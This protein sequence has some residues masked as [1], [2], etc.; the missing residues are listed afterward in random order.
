MLFI[1]QYNEGEG[2]FTPTINIMKVRLTLITE[3]G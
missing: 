2:G 3:K 1:A